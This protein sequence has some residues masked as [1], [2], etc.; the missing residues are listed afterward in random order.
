MKNN[1]E[2]WVA[3][4]TAW[5]RSGTSQAAYAA[6]RHIAKGT[7]GYWSCKLARETHDS[8]E[9]V[10]LPA[11]RPHTDGDARRAIELVVD[12]RYLLRLWPGVRAA[13]LREVMS[14]LEPRS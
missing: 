7:L 9:L 10:E 11:A 2:F 14:A 8:G 13:D 12:G 4:V 6:R 3:H 1:R 5:R